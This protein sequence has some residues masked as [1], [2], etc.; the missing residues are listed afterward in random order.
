MRHEIVHGPS[1]ALLK[2]Q[3]GAGDAI[4]AEAGAMVSHRGPLRMDTRLNAGTRA[5]FLARIFAFFVA[6]LRKLIG[7]ET[8]FINEFSATGASE[9]SLAP[10]LAG[11]VEHRRLDNERILL[12][13]GAFLA[14]G[15]GLAMRMRWGGL[16]A[17]L[18]KEGVVFL[19]VSGTGD[20]FINSYGGIRAVPVDGSFVVDNGHIVAF[21]GGLD[22]T[23][24]RPGGGMMGLFASG[25]GLVCT[26][27]GR[28]NVYIQSRNTS[29][30]VEWLARLLPR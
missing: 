4:T 30:L 14:M 1:F 23:I 28:G 27:T 6:L 12:Q 11:H 9:L 25:E 19:E 18:S 10:A 7:G 16:R 8:M 5:G 13:P 15:P 2:L 17:I 24:S 21:D 26:F 22:F 20:L 3:L 29:A